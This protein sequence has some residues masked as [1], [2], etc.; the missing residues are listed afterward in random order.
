[1]KKAMLVLFALVVALSLLAGCGQQASGPVSDSAEPMKIETLR[2]MPYAYL[3]ESFDLREVI[4][5][6]DDVEYSATAL[7]VD[8]ETRTE[9]FLDVVDLCYTPVEIQETVVTLTATRGN[10]TV[11]KVVY[12]PTSIRAEPLDDIYCSSG[13][14]GGGDPGFS[15][16]VNIDPNYLYGEDST[17]SL[18]ISWNSV[19]PHPWGNSFLNITNSDAMALFTD[20]TWEN[21]IVTFWVY[22]PND[23]AVEIQCVHVD[24][25]F[26]TDFTNTP[27]PHRMFA[28]PGKWTQCFYSVRRGG[29]VGKP[30]VDNEAYLC[31]KFRYE[32]Y[33]TTDSY[34]FEFYIDN[35]DVVPAEMYPDVDT[36]YVKSKETREQGWENS[37]TD[38]G[39]EGAYII[40]DYDQKMGEGSECSMKATFPGEKGKTHSFV[41]INPGGWPQDEW[42]DM[43]G[44]IFSGYFKFENAPAKVKLDIVNDKWETSNQVEFKLSAVGDG[45]YYGYV[46]MED[47]QVGSYRNDNIIRIRIHF[48]DVTDD[49][50]IHL[51][52]IKFNYKYVHRVFEE[53][54]ADWINMSTD[55]GPYY[56]NVKH[57]FVTDKLKGENTVRSIQAIAPANAAGRFTFN[58]SA[59]KE[60]EPGLNMRN[61]TLGAWFYF[62]TQLPNAS[63]LVTSDNWKGSIA[64]PF[65]FTK[66]TGDG[67][68]YGELHGSDIKFVEQANASRVIRITITFPAT[69][70][71]YMDNLHWFANVENDLIAAEIDPSVLYDAGDMLAG[72]KNI[73]YDDHHWEN[74]PNDDGKEDYFTGFT[75]GP[76]EDKQFTNGEKSVRAWYYKAAAGANQ[77]N[78]IAQMSFSKSYDMRNKW[79]AFDIRVD[80][81]GKEQV[82]L[83][84]RLH[85]ASWGNINEVN[86]TIKINP[87]ETYK[88][89]VLDFN[90]VYLPNAKLD[91]LSFVSFY[92][93][94]S[95]NVEYDR[96][97]YIDNVYLMDY[98]PDDAITGDEVP[99]P[100]GPEDLY[101]G[102][103]LLS[104]ATEYYNQ[105]G[106]VGE[107]KADACG[108][109]STD[110]LRNDDETNPM[111]AYSVQ[112]WKYALAEGAANFRV[113]M[114]LHKSHDLTGKNLE[115]DVKFVNNTNQTVG[116]ELYNNWTSLQKDN[117]PLLTWTGDGSEDWQK[118]FFSAQDVEAAIASSGVQTTDHSEIALMTFRLSMG[119]E[120][121][122]ERAVY[123]DNVAFTKSDFFEAEND[124]LYPATANTADWID[125]MVLEQDDINV[126]DT[127]S[128][129]SWACK[130]GATVANNAAVAT[131]DLG[132]GVDMTGKFLT[133]EGKSLTAQKLSVILY[134]EN[135]QQ[136]T[137]PIPVSADAG[138]WYTFLLEIEKYLGTSEPEA[139]EPEATEPEVVDP[140][141]TEPE[142]VDPEATEPEATEP[143][144]SEPEATEP[145][146]PA[147]NAIRYISFVFDYEENTGSD[148]AFY[149][150]NV[151][152][153]EREDKAS[154]WIHMPLLNK[155]GMQTASTGYNA[156]HVYTDGFN[157]TAPVASTLSLEA[158]ASA[159]ADSIF[160]LDVSGRVPALQHRGT[161]DVWFY[162]GNQEPVASMMVV[163]GEDNISNVLPIEFVRSRKGWFSASIDLTAVTY[164]SETH[165]GSIKGLAFAIPA[166]YT[167]CVDNISYT[168][169]VE[170]PEMDMIHLPHDEGEFDYVNVVDV[171]SAQSLYAVAPA[172]KSLNIIFTPETA[173]NMSN[174]TISAWFYFGGEAPSAVRFTASDAAANS[175]GYISFQF[176]TENPVNGWYKGTV[177]T[178][179]VTDESKAEV[180]MNVTKFAIQIRKGVA[181][182]IDTMTYV[183]NPV[184]EEEVETET[185]ESEA[186]QV[187]AVVQEEV[188]ETVEVAEEATETVEEVT[189]AVAE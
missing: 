93:N 187:E 160:T 57:A 12:I 109:V 76:T 94:F 122:G 126:A 49:T 63:M 142:V 92:F 83:G 36:T 48:S 40:Y 68:Y 101:D 178:S 89:V 180:L 185:T 176:D 8:I 31:L 9:H 112:S 156:N 128:V 33:S 4:L 177:D 123:I 6:E 97:I 20:Q 184:V 74:S 30:G 138:D 24:E 102:G 95:T 150:D 165:A 88:T 99:M 54:S 80:S 141:A 15:K 81:E 75:C 179:T 66:N 79:L 47:V 21:A 87:D 127:L 56:W 39:W 140:E 28:E 115:F 144:A 14:G 59:Q 104:T 155:D 73:S 129:A 170:T 50:V 46:D 62:G 65:V 130:A 10:E 32:D 182:N 77:S 147:L 43:T 27:G 148:R 173:M 42:P 166:G 100:L 71:I 157:G 84:L 37:G 78:V 35:L 17:T 134:N 5:M 19:D 125:D 86:K 67:W 64:L 171:N 91:Q 44:G 135:N 85:N 18:K 96:T 117:T 7:Y 136:M 133:F 113:Q 90:D 70:T 164:E 38:T 108:S 72:T 1:M 152:L 53:F 168:D 139:T 118:V 58:T 159:D 61:G 116:I 174:G 151:K 3:G 23:K 153:F 45:W 121:E 189:E 131:F 105:W 60:L 167:V 11:H 183:A 162:F 52:T 16:T 137:K 154:D 114:S 34:D 110:V 172:D 146:V 161:L 186:E 82:S 2:F 106:Q 41:C 132:A 98:I 143:E 51:D 181:V 119:S 13:S 29:T 111:S 163:D 22:N 55:S 158:V 175:S 124:L 107:G 120:T 26:Y 188:V 103:D 25:G 169:I 145:V 69:Y 149:I